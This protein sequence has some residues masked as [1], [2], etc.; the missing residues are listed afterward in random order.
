MFV[1]RTVPPGAPVLVSGGVV[2]VGSVGPVREGEEVEV[3]CRSGGGRP[4]PVVTWWW[5][6]TKLPDQVTSTTTDLAT[7][8]KT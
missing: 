6:G 7:G 1:P 2:V 3:W 4:P 5:D 8:K